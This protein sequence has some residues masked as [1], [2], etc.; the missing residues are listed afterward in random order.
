MAREAALV[1]PP[2]PP[3][4]WARGSTAGR[5]VRFSC[6]PGRS[7]C[8]LGWSPAIIH[9]RAGGLGVLFALAFSDANVHRVWGAAVVGFYPTD[10]IP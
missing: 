9:R 6:D 10:A 4:G 2:P 8:G 3:G 7:A 1:L 5:P